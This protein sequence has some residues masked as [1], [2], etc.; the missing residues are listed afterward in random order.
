MLKPETSNYI[1]EVGHRTWVGGLWDEMG[2]LQFDFLVA[3]GL[4]PHHVFLDIACGALRA[5]RFLIPYLEPGNYLGLDRHQALIDKGL[6][7][8]IDPAIVRE[9]RPEFVVSST[10]EFDK[11]S[12]KPDFCIA[13]SLFSH[14]APKDI[15]P[16]LTNLGR[17]AKPGTTFYA[18]FAE[19]R[20]TC[21]NSLRSSHSLAMFYY[22]RKEMLAFG[23]A[24]WTASYIGDWNHPRGQKMVE[25]RL[26]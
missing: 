11:F 3:H 22:T 13:Q 12:K 26:T 24:P 4:K 1:D 7:V 25:Y 10:F 2:R 19:T 9:K 20:W 8:E 21:F 6:T 16:C 17:F 23:K 15:D 18:T 5:G 14:L